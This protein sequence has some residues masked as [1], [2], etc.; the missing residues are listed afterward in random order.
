LKKF[1]K[2][3]IEGAA[4]GFFTDQLIAFNQRPRFQRKIV[5]TTNKYYWNCKTNKSLCKV[6]YIKKK[7]KTERERDKS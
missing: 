1:G 3:N 6:V 4:F 7:L 5:K 2:K